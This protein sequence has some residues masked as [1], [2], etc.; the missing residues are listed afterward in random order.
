MRKV[1]CYF[2]TLCMLF[3]FPCQVFA[4][5]VTYP[6]ITMEI[7]E[8]DEVTVLYTS[9]EIAFYYC[10]AFTGN[11]YNCSSNMLCVDF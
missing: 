2:T 10:I 3:L 8:S 4:T 9:E 11:C 5:G 1:I 7:I 6:E